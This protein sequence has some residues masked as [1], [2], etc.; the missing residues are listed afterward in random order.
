MS[1]TRDN[2]LPLIISILRPA[3]EGDDITDVLHT[4]HEHD[5]TLETQSETTVRDRSIAAEIQIPLQTL[6][7]HLHLVHA[8]LQDVQVLL[9]LRSSNQLSNL[10]HQNIHSADSL[11]IVVQLHVEGLNILGIVSHD[12]RALEHLLSEVALVLR[13]EIES[14]VGLHLEL[15]VSLLESLLQNLNSLGVGEMD[16]GVLQHIVQTSKKT[17]SMSLFIIYHLNEYGQ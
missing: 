2:A 15:D 7:G 10:G 1:Y 4:R 11:A 6:L 17:L 3:R 9:T 5:Q 13:A 16:E 8:S 14:P 12:H